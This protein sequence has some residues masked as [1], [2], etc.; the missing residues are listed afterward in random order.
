MSSSRPGI[1]YWYSHSCTLYYITRQIANSSSARLAVHQVVLILM[2]KLA[3]TQY[4]KSCKYQYCTDIDTLQACQ[5]KVWGGRKC[6]CLQLHYY[7]AESK[8]MLKP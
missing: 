7:L 6:L 4:I 8:G 1:A 5:D 2:A 3:S